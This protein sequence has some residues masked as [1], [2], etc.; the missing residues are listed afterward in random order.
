MADI[1]SI[2]NFL[3]LLGIVG[4][5][6]VINKHLNKND[7]LEYVAQIFKISEANLK[8]D[9]YLFLKEVKE[10]YE[11]H[12]NEILKLLQEQQEEV[13]KLKKTIVNEAQAFKQY[14]QDR[15][16][17]QEKI[18]NQTENRLQEAQKQIAKLENMLSKCRKKLN[19]AKNGNETS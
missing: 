6:W 8:Q 4:Y 2:L 5:L 13:E 12:Q 14:C 1:L 15:I 17:T 18:I 19:K 7:I 3:I 10:E 16:N 9:L 11:N